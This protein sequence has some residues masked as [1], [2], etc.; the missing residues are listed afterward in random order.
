[1]P[2]RPRVDPLELGA[3]DL[4]AMMIQW[5]EPPYRAD[6]LRRFALKGVLIESMTALPASLR[7]RLNETLADNRVIIVREM[8]D[9]RD[10]CAK[11][12]YRL[13]D[14]Q[15]VEGVRMRYNHGDTLCV[16]TQAGCRMGCGF[17]ASTLNGLARNLT[18]GEMLGQIAAASERSTVGNIVLMGS[19]EALDNYDSAMAFLRAVNDPQGFNIGMRRV[20]LSTCG[21]ADEIERFAS[22]GLP[23]TLCVSLHAPDDGTR[24]A[25]MPIARRYPLPRLIAA[26]KKYLRETGRRV[27]FEYALISGVND[28]PAHAR[29]LA[30]LIRGMQSH[31]NLIPLNPIPERDLRPSSEPVAA[32]FQRELESAGVS[33]TRR[34]ALG[35]GVQGAC[36]QLRQS[37]MER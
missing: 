7:S 24:R 35:G 26:C 17:C 15:C 4:R 34:R 28:S 36:G 8:A 22:E 13:S 9:D 12:L 23:V 25:L 5:G 16:S 20:S 19:G 1:M 18:A 27:I 31:V 21:M 29:R 6:Q 10:G 3:D 14:G 11:Y 37:V 33:V 32:R 30:A 2:N